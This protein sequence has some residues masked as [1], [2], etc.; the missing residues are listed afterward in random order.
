MVYDLTRWIS[1]HPGGEQAI[2]SICG[3]DGSSAFD[4]QHGG[5]SK[6]ERILA[7]YEIAPLVK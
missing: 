7:G 1:D 5:Q 2:L 6:P 3:K 4:N